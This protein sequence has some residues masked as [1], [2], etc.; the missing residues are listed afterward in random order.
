MVVE[1]HI[2]SKLK[3]VLN[4]PLPPVL[5]S[6]IILQKHNDLVILPPLSLGTPLP[7]SQN[8]SERCTAT[9]AIKRHNVHI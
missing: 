7:L 8:G 5:D 1:G 9:S 2:V 6:I 4:E 3:A